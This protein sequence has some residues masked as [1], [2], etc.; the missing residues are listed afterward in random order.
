MRSHA[1][2]MTAAVLLDQ[3]EADAA[4][5]IVMRDLLVF[6]SEG[7]ELIGQMPGFGACNPHQVAVMLLDSL[8]GNED[9]GAFFNVFD[10]LKLEGD[11]KSSQLASL[12]PSIENTTDSQ[13]LEMQFFMLCRFVLEEL[14]PFRTVAYW[15]DRSEQVNYNKDLKD[16]RNVIKIN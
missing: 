9:F 14:Y 16:L 6:I 12:I 7:Q 10:A 8:Y 11:Y 4:L 13:T 3:A 5:E 15:D 1:H 2:G